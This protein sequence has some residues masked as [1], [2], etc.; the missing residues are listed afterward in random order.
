VFDGAG[1]AVRVIEVPAGKLALQVVPQLI[2]AGAL[3]TVPEPL[4]VT[5]R[6][7]WV[8]LFP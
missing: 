7:N 4:A 1:A 5:V 6:W 3:V 2:P 8:G